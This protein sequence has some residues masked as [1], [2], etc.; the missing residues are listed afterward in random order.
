MDHD[1]YTG[2]IQ[3]L[4]TLKLFGICMV[5]KSKTEKSWNSVI[6]HKKQQ[7]LTNLCFLLR[8]KLPHPFHEN[9]S[10]LIFL[11]PQLKEKRRAS[12]GGLGAIEELENAFNLAEESCPG[13]SDRLV[14]HMMERVCR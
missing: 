4:F 2:I 12:G 10:Y 11:F 8:N 6:K 1:F 14:T 7:S 9:S 5:S 3:L 13:I